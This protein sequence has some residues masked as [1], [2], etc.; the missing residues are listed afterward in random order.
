MKF[1]I[2]RFNTW[3]A[4]KRER[5]DSALFDSIIEMI[6]DQFSPKGDIIKGRARGKD[7]YFIREDV[8][9]LRRLTLSTYYKCN[10][11]GYVK[12]LADVEAI[13]K[14]TESVVNRYSCR[15]CKNILYED[16]DEEEVTEEA[17]SYAQG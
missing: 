1:L 2:D 13:S 10:G 3:R 12:G 6:R 11:C 14:S 15:V 5:E 4:R 8:G 9:R 7:Y 17:E 16:L